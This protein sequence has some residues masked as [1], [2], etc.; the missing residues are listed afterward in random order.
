MAEVTA[1]EVIIDT[2]P[3]VAQP[4]P[5]E[6]IA[7]GEATLDDNAVRAAIMQAEANNI[8]PQTVTMQDFEQAKA[9]APITATPAVQVPAK[10]LKPD[11]TADVEK[12]A[13]STKQ[14][15]VAIQQK[16]EAVKTVEDYMREY[17]ER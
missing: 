15:D 11:G 3:R 6:A 10:F 12:I 8:D 4:Q 9:G 1:G 16:E 17:Q 14:L 7:K 2:A 5:I 13:A